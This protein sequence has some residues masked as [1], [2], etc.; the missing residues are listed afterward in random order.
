MYFIYVTFVL[1]RKKESKPK[2][3][4]KIPNQLIINSFQVHL[5]PHTSFV[6]KWNI[7]SVLT[8]FVKKK[9]KN[10]RE[11]KKEEI[12]VHV[13]LVWHW[14]G[15][16]LKTFVVNIYNGL[17]KIVN[18]FQVCFYFVHHC[19]SKTVIA[20]TGITQTKPQ[21]KSKATLLAPAYPSPC[22][23]AHFLCKKMEGDSFWKHPAVTGKHAHPGSPPA[24][25]W[26]TQDSSESRVP[27][28][29]HTFPPLE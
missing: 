12:N 3:P 27:P 21:N 25:L 6:K 2:S 19:L 17:Y 5:C 20:G 13:T 16:F 4:R 11:R 14:Y 10:E 24:P 23:P 26:L 7:F 18:Y 1:G 29:N 9:I 22:P 28:T 8:L 15:P